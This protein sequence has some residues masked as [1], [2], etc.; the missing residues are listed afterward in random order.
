VTDDGV[1][2]GQGMVLNPLK[3]NWQ[4]KYWIVMVGGLIRDY[5]RFLKYNLPLQREFEIPFLMKCVTW[6]LG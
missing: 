2:E 3:L 1:Y 4:P 5:T 6:P